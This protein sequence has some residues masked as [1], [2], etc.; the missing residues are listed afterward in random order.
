VPSHP[1][2]SK[3]LKSPPNAP[4]RARPRPDRDVDVRGRRKGAG[5]FETDCGTSPQREAVRHT[6]FDSIVR[7]GSPLYWMVPRAAA[8]DFQ[9]SGSFDPEAAL[10]LERIGYCSYSLGLSYG[11]VAGGVCRGRPRSARG[12]GALSLSLFEWAMA[13]FEPNRARSTSIAGLWFVPKSDMLFRADCPWLIDARFDADHD[14]S[15]SRSRIGPRDHG[16]GG[17]TR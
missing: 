7:P 11:R 1:A 5:C 4:L 10:G 17:F 6:K 13:N 3:A 14:Y 9:T 2:P 12:V 15:S 16:T 8:R